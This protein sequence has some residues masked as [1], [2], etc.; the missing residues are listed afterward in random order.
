MIPELLKKKVIS[1]GLV[2]YIGLKVGYWPKGENKSPFVD[3]I[4][5]ALIPTDSL[6]GLTALMMI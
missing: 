1:C 2:E 5:N 3:S 6:C 4:I